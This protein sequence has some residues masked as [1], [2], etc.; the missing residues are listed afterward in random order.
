MEPIA[1]RQVV[2]LDQLDRVYQMYEEMLL[3]RRFENWAFSVILSVRVQ[4]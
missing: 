2:K 4:L 3:M 1:S